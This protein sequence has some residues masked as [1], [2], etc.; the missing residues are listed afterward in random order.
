MTLPTTGQLALSQVQTEFGG[1]NPVRLSEYYAAGLYVPAVTPSVP[2]TG[3]VSMSAYRGKSVN[4][5][6]T[7]NYPVYVLGQVN[8]VSPWIGT[9]LI[10]NWPDAASQWIW[11][12]SGA[13][14]AAPTNVTVRLQAQYYNG[15]GAN[16]AATI[17]AG[18]DNS[19]TVYVNNAAVLT[20]AS[21][22]PASTANVTLSPGWNLI[23]LH[24]VNAGAAENP[25]GAV[26]SMYVSGAVVLRSGSGWTY[27]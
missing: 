22:T 10:G 1:S 14:T 3:Q 11:N 6:V 27:Y 21:W 13:P 2:K 4:V 16:Q 15:S 25:A 7:P 20:V 17:W 26:F 23:T 12:T 8:V 5:L 18:I 24:G 9:N 19:G